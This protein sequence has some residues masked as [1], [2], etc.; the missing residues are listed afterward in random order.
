MRR[1]AGAVLSPAQLADTWASWRTPCSSPAA[2]PRSRSRALPSRAPPDARSG[3][4]CPRAGPRCGGSTEPRSRP[5]PSTPPI[6]ETTGENDGIRLSYGL[7]WGLLWSKYG[8]ACFK[9]GH[10]DG[11][12]NYAITFEEPRTGIVIMTNSDNGESIFMELLAT[13]IGDTFTPW[14]WENYLPYD[15]PPG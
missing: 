7:G 14:R 10:D 12:Q 11:F 2:S 6:P 15:R 3:S 9:E 4:R 5:T 8:K 1:G 13:L